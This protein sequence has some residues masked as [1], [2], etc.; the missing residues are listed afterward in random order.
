MQSNNW[1]TLPQIIKN[2][3][4]ST[5]PYS[6]TRLKLIYKLSSLWI[7]VQL[8]K[9]KNITDMIYLVMLLLKIPVEKFS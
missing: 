1:D 3:C 2:M 8:K 7:L 9:K 6:D 4:N 5:K